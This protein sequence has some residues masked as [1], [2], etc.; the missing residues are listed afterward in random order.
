MD[1]KMDRLTA[2]SN[3][4]RSVFPAIKSLASQ[5]LGTVQM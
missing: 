2:D 5:S 1:D 4:R 3:P